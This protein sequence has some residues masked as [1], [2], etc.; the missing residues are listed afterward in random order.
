MRPG[1]LRF[2]LLASAVISIGVALFASA[3]GLHALFGHHV[4]R[5]LETQ[6]ETFI[7]ELVGHIEPDQQGGFRLTQPLSDPRFGQPHSGLYWQ[8]QEDERREL[9][10]SRSL[11]D[12]VLALPPDELDLGIVHQHAL[13][14]PDGQALLVREQQ[15]I[16]FPET[17]P[18]R[19]RV[20]VA[21]D[22]TDLLQ[23]RDAFSRDMLPY[24][25]LL[26]TA[27]LLATWWQI[28]T[29]LA[30][31]QHIR[32]GV[33]AVHVGKAQRLT[34]SCPEEVRPLIGEI[35]KL[36]DSRDKAIAD[37]R[38]W[39]ADLAH[40]LKTP[41]AA[42]GADAQRLRD[43]GFAGMA[44]DLDALAQSMRQRVDRELIR[45]R[46]RT[47]QAGPP[48]SADLKK[49][50]DGL[51]NTLRRTP[52]GQSVQWRIDVPDHQRVGLS[53]ADATELL[54][55]LLDNAVKWSRSQVSVHSTTA[56]HCHIL[57]EDDGPGVAPEQLAL[58]GQRGVRLDEQVAGNGLG[59][60]IARDI[61]DA[62]GGELRLNPAPLG[63]LQVEL[64]L[65]AAQGKAG[66]PPG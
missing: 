50:L 8:I 52:D 39:T 24:L 16:M 66:I 26:G 51:V 30:P 46:L 37:A 35:N 9:L 13:P 20:A 49:V 56:G 57:I 63:G 23:A 27:L 38:A 22:R 59:L 3:F 31:L 65:P 44:D 43:Q 36:L 54:G 29:G 34:G 7:A 42:L 17:A 19:L 40:G 21:I 1:S 48:K 14:G 41:L 6:L 58:L 18:R 10:R 2:R 11:W 55:N 15:V 60:A 12:T 25:M 28:R 61:V 4:E 33:F 5:Q 62:Y 53:P 47:E 45:A 64:A 32:E